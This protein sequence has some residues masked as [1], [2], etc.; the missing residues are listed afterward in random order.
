MKKYALVKLRL[1]IAAALTF[2]GTVVIMTGSPAKVQGVDSPGAITIKHIQDRYGPVVF[3]HAMHEAIAEGCGTCH[4]SHND[5]NNST[6]RECHA[7]AADA[8]KASASHG[9][10]ACSA[11]HSDY[12]PDMP[13]MPGL[14]VAFHKKCFQCHVGIG[15][16]G[17]SP[18]GCV[19]TCHS[20]S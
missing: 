10:M 18:A 13:E 16:L 14:K 11:C 7:L 3:D 9:F 15:E 6:C 2:A 19:Q 5:K 17:S 8:F 12:S 4:H 20:R 1:L